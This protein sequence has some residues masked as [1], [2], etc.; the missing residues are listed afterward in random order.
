MEKCFNKDNLQVQIYAV[1][2]EMGKGAAADIAE[3]ITS[4]LEK[5][6]CCNMIFAAAPSQHEVLEALIVFPEI[7]WKRVNAFHMDEYIGLSADAPQGFANFLR[8]ELFD[9]VPFGSVNCLDSTAQPEDE[10]VRYEGLLRKNPIDIVVMGIGENGHIA[11]N[12]PHVALFEDPVLV[13]S[14]KLDETCRMQ[15]VHDGCFGQLPDVPQMAMTLTIPALVGAKQAFCIVPASS[16]A[17]AVFDTLEGEICESC[18]ASIL[19]RHSA[20]K[21]YLDA[22]SAAKLS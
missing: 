17:Q 8:R 4:V 22:D 1:R 20:A 18:P 2:K 10:A 16:K 13:K 7:N 12:D 15:Q 14:V 9:R 11:F 3:A 5:K 19:R 6:D 21:L